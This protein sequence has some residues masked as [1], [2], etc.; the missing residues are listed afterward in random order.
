VPRRAALAEFAELPCC[1]TQG[2]SV[3]EVLEDASDAA[4]SW[5][6]ALR[7]GGRSIP[8]T[9][10]TLATSEST[11]EH[12]MPESALDDIRV[13]DLAGETGVYCTKLL[14]DLGADVI[15]IEPPE[16]DPLR[17]VGPF[18]HDVEAA[19]RSLA[20]LHLNTNKRS[21]S[22][23]FT[24]P[25]GR[26]LFEKLVATA[27]VV[28]ETHE[29]GTLDAMGLGY[30]GLSKIKSGI[31][32][33]SITGFGQTGPHARWKW[34]DIVAVGMSGMMTLAGDKEDPPNRPYGNQGY[35]CASINGAA[36]TLMA[37]Y[38]RDV[39]GEGQHVDVSMQESLSI[40]QE[41]AMMTYDMNQRVAQRTGARGI[42]PIDIPGIGIYEALDGQVFAYLGTPGG[43]PWT[44]M[45]DWMN[46]EGK[47]EDLNEEPNITMIRS[48]NLAFL[49]GLVREPEKLGER[50]KVLGHMY[51]VFSRFI[52]SLPKQYIYE[53]AQKQRLMI[54]I[55]STPE[56]LAKNPQ[57]TARSWYQDL[58]HDN[59][60][61]ATV[62]LAGPP[63][64]LSA[65]PWRLARRAP[66]PG[67]H[68]TDVYLDELGLGRDE[69]DRLHKE[70][71]I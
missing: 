64:R 2:E 54:G 36:G 45:L 55:V 34:S 51:G 24:K 11:K 38:H 58:P 16:G 23:D 43:A 52:A 50:V 15:R 26:A 42:I 10:L 41:T 14:A 67:E 33:T 63:Y 27:D 19:D 5:L 65:T 61:G 20:F 18:W 57:L 17:D 37:L 62:R 31:I 6:D 22:L 40:N 4:V 25:E 69:F 47:A 66:L 39:T 35:I 7:E 59:L 49:T 12:P 28:V 68:N 13:L 70:K 29:P 8:D 60:D 30:D 56:D 71:V 3:E 9:Q 32:L 46:R 44:V 21:I 1:Y 48:L 53:E